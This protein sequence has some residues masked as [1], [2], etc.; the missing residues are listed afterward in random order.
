MRKIFTEANIKNIYSQ[1]LEEGVCSSRE[2]IHLHASQFV[3]E[4]KMC[5]EDHLSRPFIIFCGPGHNGSVG[6]NIAL[7]LSEKIDPSRQ[8]EIFLFKPPLG[9]R[10]ESTLLKEQ[11]LTVRNVLLH[12]IDNQFTPPQ[13]DYRHIVIDALF[14]T[15]LQVPLRPDSGFGRLIKYINGNQESNIISVD[16]PSGLS[17]DINH[18]TLPECVIQATYT[19]S[20]DF[21]KLSSFFE[22]N[23]KFYGDLRLLEFNLSETVEETLTTR[24]FET[25]DHDIE[26]SLKRNHQSLAPRTRDGVLLIGGTPKNIGSLILATKG[27]LHSGVSHVAVQTSSQEELFL[28]LKVPEVTIIDSIP[29]ETLGISETTSADKNSIPTRISALLPYTAIGLGCGLTYSSFVK[30]YLEHLFFS[31]SDKQFVF[32]EDAVALLANDEDLFEILPEKSI[33]ILSRNAFDKLLKVV[34]NTEEQRIEQ[35]S[36]FAKRKNIYLILQG[37]KTAICLPNGSVIFNTGGT[38]EKVIQGGNYTLMGIV[39]SLLA[40]NYSPGTASIIATHLYGLACDLYIG[41]Y[42]YFSLTASDIINML[43]EV[44]RQIK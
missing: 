40:Q 1:S 3:T 22:E 24:Y 44:F 33:L 27:A 36:S 41:K 20:L 28:Q 42:S 18:E 35:A 43:P 4:L 21:P 9:L 37:Y 31:L 14:G 34:S 13:I 8:I 39:V 29:L 25:T 12:E 19:F 5:Y 16:I 7:I 6:L 2:L 11:L 30:Q 26:L 17:P 15:D 38:S 32:D 23:R 10:E